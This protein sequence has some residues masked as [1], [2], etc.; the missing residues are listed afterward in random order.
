MPSGVRV[1]KPREVMRHLPA[2][3]TDQLVGAANILAWL[4]AS[5][6][7]KPPGHPEGE[8]LSAHETRLG[9]FI[10]TFLS[11]APKPDEDE[12]KGKAETI[13][14]SAEVGA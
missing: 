3:R 10:E 6:Y 8:T 4:K 12:T 14:L 5:P 1:R 2:P 11:W 7:W 9:P 13:D